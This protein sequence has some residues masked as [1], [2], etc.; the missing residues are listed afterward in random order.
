M[1]FE[2]M[3]P[4]DHRGEAGKALKR[5]E[6][7]TSPEKAAYHLAL[8]QVH[9]TLALGLYVSAISSQTLFVNRVA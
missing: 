9:A 2:A 6:E 8:A 3:G 1:E 4:A 7:M 5:A